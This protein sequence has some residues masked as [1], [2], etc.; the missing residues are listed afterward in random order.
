[1]AL[2][3][4]IVAKNAPMVVTPVEKRTMMRIIQSPSIGETYPLQEEVIE[5]TQKLNETEAS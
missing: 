2:E 4:A 3:F 5:I 1:V